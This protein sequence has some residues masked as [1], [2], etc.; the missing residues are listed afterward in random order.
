MSSTIIKVGEVEMKKRKLRNPQNTKNTINVGVSVVLILLG[1]L[2]ITFPWFGIEEPSKLLYILFTVYAGLKICEYI[3]TRVKGD[4]EDLYTGIASAIAALSGI[5]FI[6]YD[7]PTVLGITLISWVGIMSIIKL[8]KLDYY[9]D[10]GNVMLYVN[11]IT[12]SLFLLLGILTSVNLYFDVTVQ[13]LML[14]FFFVVNGLLN[15]A[16]DGIRMLLESGVIKIGD[17]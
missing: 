10:R 11:L 15:L 9:H 7:V 14:G 8:I 6:S 4:N 5:K 3:I 12:F 2:L 17:K 13:T 1:V 16:E